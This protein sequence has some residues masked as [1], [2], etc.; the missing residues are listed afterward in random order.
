MS[1]EK[2]VFA[3]DISGHFQFLDFSGILDYGT[4]SRENVNFRTIDGKCESLPR[5]FFSKAVAIGN[6]NVVI[7]DYR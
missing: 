7:D 3:I 4:V 5:I 6:K 1:T 2:S